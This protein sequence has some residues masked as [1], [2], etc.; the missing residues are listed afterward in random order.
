MASAQT[1]HPCDL[2]FPTP[3]SLTGTTSQ[4]LKARF[5]VSDTDVIEAA[6]I[7]S[8][9]VATSLGPVTSIT[10]SNSAGWKQVEVNVGN[11]QKGSFSITIAVY[12]HNSASGALQESGQSAPFG[13][14]VTDPVG[15]PAPLPSPSPLKLTCP[16]DQSAFSPTGQPVT[17]TYA[18]PQASGGTPPVT[19]TASPASG[20]AM[21]VG[22]TTVSAS[23]QD[24]NGQ[25]SSCAFTVTVTTSAPREGRSPPLTLMCP[26]NQSASSPTGQPVT[27]TYPAPQSSGGTPPVTVIASPARGTAI[28]V[29][30]T[31]VSAAAQDANGQ[32]ASCS[33]TVTVTAVSQTP[34]TVTVTSP[35]E[36]HRAIDTLL[37]GTTILIKPGT[38]RLDRELRIRNV[39][40]V[41]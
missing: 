39:T 4:S 15:S 23:A 38:Y 6:I 35:S 30:T 19:L 16:S 29:G 24:A 8:N 9:G 1:L 18:A 31:S 10:A 32:R 36:L 2:A 21:L 40:K 14:L 13:L 22:T 41:T 27:L 7:R 28:P 33:F 25:R 26:A 34:G 5:C 17:V 37:S 12:N 20:T 11:F 3:T